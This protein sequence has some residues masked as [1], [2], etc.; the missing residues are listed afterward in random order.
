MVTL[1]C[2]FYSKFSLIQD[3]FENE[4]DEEIEEIIEYV[5]NTDEEGEEIIEINGNEHRHL[6]ENDA[7]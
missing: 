2:T 1:F 4:A 3:D 7:N 5:D 6:N